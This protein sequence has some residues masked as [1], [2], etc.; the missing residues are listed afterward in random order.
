MLAESQLE[1]VRQRCQAVLRENWREGTRISDGV[2]FAYTCPSPG[3]Y[4]WQWYWDS[5]FTAIAGRHFDADRS[6]RELESLL[7]AQREDGFIGHTIFWNEPLSGSRRYTYNVISPDAP[8]TAS[9]QPPLLAWAW[10]IA[11]GDPAA[12]PGIGRHH[13]WLAEHR[14]LDG[15][16][17]IWIVQ[18][19]ES[20]LDASP[21]FDAIWGHRAHGRARFVL[22]VRRNHH[23]GYDLRRIA[24]HGGPVCCEVTTNVLYNLSRLAL[25]LPSLTQ[26]LVER[27]YNEDRGLFL[28]LARQPPPSVSIADP[29]FSLNDTGRIGR[30]RYWRG[31]TW[32]NAAWLC[33]IGL[34]RL[35][36]D[37]Q[38]E[39]L[40]E[41][42][43]AAVATAGLR[44]YYDPYTGAGMGAVAD[45]EFIARSPE[46]QDRRA[47]VPGHGHRTRNASDRRGMAG[48][49]HARAVRGTA[50][51]RHRATVHRRL[52]RRQG[53]RHVP[54]RRLRR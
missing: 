35:G 18:P 6:R 29:S 43:G 53:R 5:C 54:L 3:H 11:V 14:D 8:M 22:L 42:L 38:A 47:N 15:D 25:G 41:R 21:Q 40:G 4:P 20:G 26:T 9:I 48:A 13:K 44:E 12:V 28:P 45:R 23:L 50:Q 52:R 36:Y 10:R 33:W 19:D 27:T 49:T 30:R 2:P 34:V 1:L 24:D 51:T 37:T 39:Q 17:L 16:G 7:A 31:P 46:R 32:I